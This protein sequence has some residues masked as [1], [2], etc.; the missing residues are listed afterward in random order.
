MIEDVEEFESEIESE[1][2]LDHRPLQYA[3]IGVVE[4]RAVEETP[5]R[6]PKSSESA[7]LNECAGGGHTG[8]R[9]GD[10][11]RLRR[12]EVASRVGISRAIWIR[13]TRIQSLDLADEIR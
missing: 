7:I 13:V 5:V 11:G 10:R 1:I 4:S 8:I 12:D 6:G 3:E 2:V 9:I